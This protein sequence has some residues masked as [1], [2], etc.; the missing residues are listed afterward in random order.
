MILIDLQVNSVAC[1]QDFQM[2]VTGSDD[3]RVR[4]F[5]AKTAQFICKLKGHEGMGECEGM[6]ECKSL[7]GMAECS[8]ECEWLVLCVQ[9]EGLKAHYFKMKYSYC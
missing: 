6:E 9:Y 8:N 5:N 1:S 4:I 2:L 7:E 3:Q